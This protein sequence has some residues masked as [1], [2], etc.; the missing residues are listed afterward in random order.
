MTR[1]NG[2]PATGVTRRP[3]SAHTTAVARRLVAPSRWRVRY[4]STTGA[5]RTKTFARKLDAENFITGTDHAKSAGTYVDVSAG[6]I[7]FGDYSSGWL[8]RKRQTTKATTAETFASHLRRHLLPRF[9]TAELRSITRE[10]VKHFAGSLSTIVAPTTAR[11]VVFTLTAV[12]R[13]AVDDGRLPRNPAERVT[14]GAKT[15]RWSTRCTSPASPARSRRWR[16]RCPHGGAP[17]CCS[18]RRQ[19]SA[20]AS[21]SG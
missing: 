16:T 15:E 17:P 4:R 18:W 3:P 6:R 21:A 12:L 7:S 2:F 19:G 13:E 1:G 8:A 20:S 5:S 14:V 11:A 10:Q 9:G